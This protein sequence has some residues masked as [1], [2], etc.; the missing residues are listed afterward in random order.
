MPQDIHIDGLGT[1][2]L[3]VTYIEEG[4]SILD[5]VKRFGG[6]VRTE[7]VP[8][9]PR[10]ARKL[11]PR[12]ECLLAEYEPEEADSVLAVFWR[13]H[14][15]EVEEFDTP[16]EAERFLDGGEEYGALAGE[17]V[18]QRKGRRSSEPTQSR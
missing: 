18:V 9:E 14:S 16:E 1:E 17:A 6:T 13:Y 11:D 5:L 4:A 7:Y 12:T 2:P 8:E 15:L 10:P 3:G